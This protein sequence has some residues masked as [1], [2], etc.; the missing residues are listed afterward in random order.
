MPDRRLLAE[1]TPSRDFGVRSKFRDGFG[2]AMACHDID[3]SYQLRQIEAASIGLVTVMPSP[4]PCDV[5][6]ASKSLSRTNLDVIWPQACASPTPAAVHA[7]NPLH[8]LPIPTCFCALVSSYYH[9]R[10]L[11]APQNS[12]FLWIAPGQPDLRSTRC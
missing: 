5:C 2:V 4:Q 9:S 3:T 1:Q 7:I 11:A 12:S 8:F 10:S 6:A